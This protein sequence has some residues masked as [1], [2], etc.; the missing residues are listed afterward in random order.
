[1]ARVRFIERVPKQGKNYYLVDACF[2]VNKHIEPKYA[3][4][5]QQRERLVACQDWWSEI[6]AQLKARNARVYVP[7][8]CIAEA[9]KVLAKKRYRENWLSPIA[10]AKAKKQLSKDVTTSVRELKKYDRTVAYHDISTH[11][12]IIISVDR[13]FELFE[14]HKKNVSIADLIIVATAK[15]V[16]DFFDIPKDLLHIVTLDDHLREGIGK[17][18]ELPRAYDP[19][20]HGHRAARVF[21][22]AV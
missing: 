17:A 14:K 13:Y 8:I 16:M 6:D 11:R 9:F 3:P 19:S 1:M 22:D 20:L 7:D 5:E 2:L 18:T 15:Y 4:N 12:D 10:Y 21:R